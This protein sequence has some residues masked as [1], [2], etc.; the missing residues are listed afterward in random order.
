MHVER[1]VLPRLMRRCPAIGR[2]VPVDCRANQAHRGKPG[3]LETILVWCGHGYSRQL[4]LARAVITAS[5]S[6]AIES[7][8]G[9]GIL[10]GCASP[11]MMAAK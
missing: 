11:W 5:H 9:G 6:G 1:M 10:V 3:K 8:S 4:A 7:R 2:N